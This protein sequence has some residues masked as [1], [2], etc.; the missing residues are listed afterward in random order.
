MSGYAMGL[1]EFNKMTDMFG[2]TEQM[3]VLFPWTWQPYECHR[4]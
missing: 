3:P 4:G 1:K 2:N